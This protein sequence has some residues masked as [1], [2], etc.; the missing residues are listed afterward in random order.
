MQLK[1]A[2]RGASTPWIGGMVL[3]LL[4]TAALWPTSSD[5]EYA[6]D[7]W[8]PQTAAAELF[9]PIQE[10]EA[11]EERSFRPRTVIPRHIRPIVDA[12]VVAADKAGELVRD[13]DLVLGVAVNG[14][15]RAYPINLLC[16]PSR[17][18]VNDKL[19]GQAIAAT[20]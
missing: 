16:G 17:E 7:G 9:D 3:L 13:H 12:P 10:E 20:W 15:A 14:E 5:V 11:S 6:R 18:I 1:S 4:T 19:G 2:S 8:A